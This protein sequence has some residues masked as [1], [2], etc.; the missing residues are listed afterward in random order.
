MNISKLK[1]YSLFFEKT[2]FFFKIF[3]FKFFLLKNS[4]MYFIL[5][6][7]IFLKKV[8]NSISFIY[9][10]LFKKKLIYFIFYFLNFLKKLNTL[11]RKKIFLTGLGF[12]ITLISPNLL[13]FK[14]G[15]SHLV[16]LKVPLSITIF[17]IKNNLYLESYNP[18]LLGTFSSVIKNLKFPDNYKGKGFWFKSGKKKLKPVK[19]S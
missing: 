8:N 15:F 3:K 13:S 4:N 12:K 17:I 11:N 18:A 9:S 10:K 1:N 2:T 7:Y 14:I 5:P 6:N 19:K 16:H